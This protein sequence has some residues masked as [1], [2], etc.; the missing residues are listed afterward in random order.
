MAVQAAVPEIQDFIVSEASV[1]QTGIAEKTLSNEGVVG[2]ESF[3][4]LLASAKTAKSIYAARYG[5]SDEA[6]YAAGKIEK[7]AEGLSDE[8]LSLLMT[9]F[10]NG[11]ERIRDFADALDAE[12]SEGDVRGAIELAGKAVEKVSRFDPDLILG[13]EFMN[14]SLHRLIEEFLEKFRQVSDVN[15]HPSQP[16]IPVTPLGTETVEIPEEPETA[17]PSADPERTEQKTPDEDLNLPVLPDLPDMSEASDTSKIPEEDIAPAS[18]DELEEGPEE[19]AGTDVRAAA[20]AEF[21]ELIRMMDSSQ[22]DKSLKETKNDPV[23]KREDQDVS[24]A[25]ERAVT[26]RTEVARDG[27]ESDKSG[28]DGFGAGER[29]KQPG[30][31]SPTVNKRVAQSAAVTK[32]TKAE[33]HSADPRHSGGET[34]AASVFADEIASAMRSRVGATETTVETRLT[35]PG[36]TYELNAQNPFAD[37]VGSALEFMSSDGINEARIVVEP[38]ALGRIDVSLQASGSGMEAVFKVDNEALKNMLQQQ[39]DVLKTSLEAQGIHVS[40]LAVDIRNRDD[41]RSSEDLYGSRRKGGRS[42]F[43]GIEETEEDEP[44]IARLDLEKGLL[45]WVA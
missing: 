36:T 9:P 15:T 45:H 20:N 31:L 41:Q 23:E 39:L 19:T 42:G 37:G 24:R 8:E 32:D 18:E 1:S 10:S 27:E 3:D 16:M 5:M 25:F 26:A 34:Q 22:G 28:A 2:R 6:K 17:R 11:V 33:L 44:R 21:L 7:F 35:Q 14:G 30:D 38:P 4:R 12:L 29:N 40:N 13:G 43:G